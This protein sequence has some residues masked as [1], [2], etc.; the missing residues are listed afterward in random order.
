MLL[1]AGSAV[2]MLGAGGGIATATPGAPTA[3]GGTAPSSSAPISAPSTP[4]SSNPQSP[5]TSEPPGASREPGRH[6]PSAARAQHWGKPVAA[7]SNDFSGP[8]DGSEWLKWGASNGG[9][10]PSPEGDSQRCPSQDQVKNGNLVITDTST[11][12]G[13]VESQGTL[14]EPYAIEAREKSAPLNHNGAPHDQVMLAFP[15][16]QLGASDNSEVDY[17]EGDPG[18]KLHFFAHYGTDQTTQHSGTY[19]APS[20]RWHT[21]AVKVTHSRITMYFDGQE[22]KTMPNDSKHIPV[23]VG[24]G[25]MDDLTQG[26]NETDRM[27]IDFVHAYQL[28]RANAPTPS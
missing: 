16:K 17:A 15:T 22:V 24:A 19:P 8:L 2:G 23:V 20:N 21:Y 13:G 26:P 14:H 4:W 5:S 6:G 27:W 1:A 11:K 10:A 18:S 7:L 3:F 12:T 28:G 9:C 25:Q